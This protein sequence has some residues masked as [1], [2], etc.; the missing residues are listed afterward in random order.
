MGYLNVEAT[1]GVFGV[2]LAEGKPVVK[3]EQP[4]FD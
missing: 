3:S 2:C 1:V 4:S